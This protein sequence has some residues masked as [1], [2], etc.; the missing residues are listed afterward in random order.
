MNENKNKLINNHNNDWLSNQ[1]PTSLKQKGPPLEKIF[2]VF[3]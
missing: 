1:Y 3:V 2:A